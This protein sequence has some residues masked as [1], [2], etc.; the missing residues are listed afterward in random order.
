LTLRIMELDYI[1]RGARD[2]EIEKVQ[3]A[4]EKAALAEDR[5]IFLGYKD[6]G[7]SGI[8]ESSPHPPLSLSKNRAEYLTSI[9]EAR[10]ILRGAGISGPYGLAVGLKEGRE[11]ALAS[12][13]GYP[14]E[15]RVREFIEGPI[16]AAGAIEGMVLISM[17]GGDFILTVG[18]DLSIGYAH[19]EKHT[20]EL[21]ITESFTFRVV[22]PSAAIYIRPP[23]K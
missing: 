18:Q 13:D 10:E 12:Q 8:I 15:K 2:P 5:A 20:V 11:L 21:Y 16:V 3:R 7:I 22:E 19:Q 4:A 14:V 17:R 23:S 9:L 6:A 1:A